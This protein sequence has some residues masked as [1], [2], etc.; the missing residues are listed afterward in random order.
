MKG[1][2]LHIN[3]IDGFSKIKKPVE[4]PWQVHQLFPEYQKTPLIS[5]KDEA[6][7]FGINSILVKDE[8]NRMSLNSFKSLGAAYAIYSIKEKIEKKGLKIVAATAGNHGLGVAYFANYYGL[9][10][11]III[12]AYVSKKRRNFLKVSGQK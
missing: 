8:S 5:L 11:R 12:P 4:K 10:C 7:K 3:R 2:D 1:I 6:L 9:D